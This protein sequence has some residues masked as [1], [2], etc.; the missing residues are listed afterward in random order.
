MDL[1]G[2]ESISSPIT[3]PAMQREG[4]WNGVHP[5]YNGQ[6]SSSDMVDEGREFREPLSYDCWTDPLIRYSYEF[7]CTRQNAY[8]NIQQHPGSVSM[9][10]G[11]AYQEQELTDMAT[12]YSATSAN[13]GSPV[14]YTTDAPPFP[15]RRK[16]PL[17]PSTRDNARKMRKQG[18]CFRC[19]IMKEK[20]VLDEES[21]Y[22]GMCKRCRDVANDCRTWQL[23]CSKLKLQDRFHFM[24]PN[25]LISHLSR[26]KVREYIEHQINGF[27]AGSSF[28]LALGMDF[29]NPLEFNAIEFIPREQKN[30]PLLAFGLTSTGSTTDLMLESPPIMPVLVDVRAIMVHLNSWLDSVSRDTTSDFPGYCFPGAHE[31]WQREILTN[32]CTYHRTYISKLETNGLGPFQTLRWA[33]KLTILN[34]IMCHP[35]SVPDDK[36]GPLLRQLS[37]RPVRQPEWVC[38]R[39]AN[40]VI[41]SYCVPL[42]NKAISLVLEHLHRI[43]RTTTKALLWDQAFSIVFLCLIVIAKNQVA[44]IERAKVCMA[45]GDQSFSMQDAVEIVREMESELSSYLIGMFH[46]RFSTKK[47]G[48][49]NGKTFN[50][51][52]GHPGDGPQSATWLMKSVRRATELYG[53]SSVCEEKCGYANGNVGWTMIKQT[54]ERSL[55]ELLSNDRMKHMNVTRLLCMFLE[56]FA[57]QDP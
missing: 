28:K 54:A 4:P 11:N 17:S 9:A 40:K 56:P 41:K 16:R 26:S 18:S 39:L 8:T 33:L 20:C 3:A 15:A 5:T 27:V 51:L 24:L 52:A 31:H 30:A 32:I 48:N 10:T 22:D 29:G 44:L 2:Q 45:D 37:Y 25:A 14:S 36:V 7:H 35:F 46:E 34:H 23:P 21:E 43:L 47:K 57:P 42:L 50:P 1:D 6:S 53:K 19:H 38:P 55:S 13:G 49:G 12:T